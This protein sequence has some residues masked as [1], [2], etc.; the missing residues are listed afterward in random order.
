[1]FERCQRIVDEVAALEDE[2]SG[3]RAAVR[4][5]LRIDA[6]FTYGKQV[7]LPILQRLLTQ[8]PELR[9]DLRLSDAYTDR[10]VRESTRWFESVI[11]PTCGWLRACLISKI[12][13]FAAVRAICLSTVRVVEDIKA[14]GLWKS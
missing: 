9:L 14:G 2:A 12:F 4:G 10:S 8:Y 1:L 7:V 6:P 5:V 13:W 11:C 3:A